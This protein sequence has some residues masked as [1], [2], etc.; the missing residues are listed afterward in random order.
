MKE[1]EPISGII[2]IDEHYKIAYYNQHFEKG[3][4]LNKTVNEYLSSLIPHKLIKNGNRDETLKMYLGRMKLD[5][6]CFN[7]STSNTLRPS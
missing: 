1:I 4:D 5:I 3:L 7:C 6:S 2:N